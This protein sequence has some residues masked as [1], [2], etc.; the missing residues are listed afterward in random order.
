MS[1]SPALE[2]YLARL[3][4]LAEGTDH[5]LEAALRPTLV[6]IAEYL[7]ERGPG[8]PVLEDLKTLCCHVRGTGRAWICD[9]SAQ[10]LTD[11]PLGT[12]RERE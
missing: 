2:E 12:G 10:G 7:R 9:P 1:V 11:C 4:S 5:T 8:D 6:H 3:K